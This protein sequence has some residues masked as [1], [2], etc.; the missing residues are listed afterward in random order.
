MGMRRPAVSAQCM[1]SLVL[2]WAAAALGIGGYVRYVAQMR[3]GASRPN[4]V[5]WALWA[6]L[7]TTN[8][9]TYRAAVDTVAALQFLAG[10][11]ACVAVF[12]YALIVGKFERPPARDIAVGALALLALGVWR[13]LGSAAWANVLIAAVFALSMLPTILGLIRGVGREGAPAWS[14]W[15]LASLATAM[16][17]ALRNSSAIA[18]VTPIVLIVSYSAVIALARRRDD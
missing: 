17:A 9:L 18:F 14:L 8:A 3:T 1:S 16:N 2:G 10:A 6:L 4:V 13:V 11:V 12:A 7:A 15:L 5:S